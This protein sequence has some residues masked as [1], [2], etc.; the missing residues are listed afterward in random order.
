MSVFDSV[1]VLL[2]KIF[3]GKRSTTG[4]KERHGPTKTSCLVVFLFASL[5]YR[6]HVPL[7]LPFNCEFKIL[8]VMLEDGE[9]E[10]LEDKLT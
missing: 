7:S 2:E 9:K 1:S 3:G 5:K 4:V 10:S 8:Q 6:H